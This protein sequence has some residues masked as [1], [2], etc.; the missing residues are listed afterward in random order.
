MKRKTF[1]F[2]SED[3]IHARLILN[4]EKIAEFVSN[5]FDG[6]TDLMGQMRSLT[7]HY[8]GLAKLYVRNLTVG[9]SFE[10]PLML[11]PSTYHDSESITPPSRM[12]FGNI[13]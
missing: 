13:F 9:W 8:R 6:M 5:R 1:T 12:A 10:R 3:T 4:G 7:R 2:S 11:Y